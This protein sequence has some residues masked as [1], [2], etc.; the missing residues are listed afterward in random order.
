MAMSVLM[1]LLYRRSVGRV[2]QFAGCCRCSSDGRH[3][4]V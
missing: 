2:A 4:D 3:V 1:R